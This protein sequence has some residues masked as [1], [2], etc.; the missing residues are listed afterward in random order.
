MNTVMKDQQE[1][2]PD[3]IVNELE[4]CLQQ[5]RKAYLSDPLPDYEQRKDVTNRLNPGRV[6]ASQEDSPS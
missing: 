4:I 2:N 1:N 6:F 3:S 5:Q